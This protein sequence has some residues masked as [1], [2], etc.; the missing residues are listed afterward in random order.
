MK[1][2]FHLIRHSPS[3]VIT[4]LYGLLKPFP[5]PEDLENA[6]LELETGRRYGRDLVLQ[7]L[8]GYGYAK[9]DLI[10]SP[11]EYA[12]RGGIVD[13]FSPWGKFPYRVEFSGDE[14]VSLREFDSS[15]QRS[16]TK[17]SRILL[18]SLREFPASARFLDEWKRLA[19]E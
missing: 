16:L 18:P 12:W 6:F 11:G 15:T 14:V 2:F 3:L 5:V 13:V 19:L 7:T 17:L 8:S 1:F 4:N 10:V 9:E